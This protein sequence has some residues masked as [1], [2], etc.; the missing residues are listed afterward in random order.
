MSATA[1]TLGRGLSAYSGYNTGV[2]RGEGT[3]GAL[4][5][6]V[7]A[8]AAT[9]ALASAVYNRLQ[10]HLKRLV[11]LLLMLHHKKELTLSYSTQTTVGDEMKTFKQLPNRRIHRHS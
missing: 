6:G 2:Q 3:T 11:L 10:D 1:R 9:D 5:R 8:A 7:A 4:V